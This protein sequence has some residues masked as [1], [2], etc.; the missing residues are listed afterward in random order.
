M[1]WC[2]TILRLRRRA[3]RGRLGEALR[4]CGAGGLEGLTIFALDNANHIGY[5]SARLVHLTP[6]DEDWGERLVDGASSL[7]AAKKALAFLAAAR[8]VRLACAHGFGCNPQG[9]GSSLPSA[10]SRDTD[11]RGYA[12]PPPPCH[13]ARTAPGKAVGSPARWRGRSATGCRRNFGESR[14]SAPAVPGKAGIEPS[15]ARTAAAGTRSACGEPHAA[16]I[17]RSF[18]NYPP[19]AR[20]PRARPRRA[21]PAARS[22]CQASRIRVRRRSPSCIQLDSRGRRGRRGGCVPRRSRLSRFGSH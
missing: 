18:A 20:P 17:R 13:R 4:G 7:S 2:E 10:G 8:P 21:A 11:V 15:L 12:A 5:A 1:P 14:P 9:A 16:R 6:G 22:E 19:T 3:L